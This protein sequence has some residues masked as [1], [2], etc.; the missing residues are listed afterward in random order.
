MSKSIS[1]ALR[2]HLAQECTTLA[3][4]WR[5]TRTDGQAFYLTDHD[6][7]LTIGGQTYLADS[8]YTRTAVTSSAGFRTDELEVTGLFADG[9]IEEIEVR[10]GLFD[11]AEAEIFLVDFTSPTTGRL[12]LRIGTLGEIKI[13][14]RRGFTAEIRGRLQALSQKIGGKYQPE[15]RADVGDSRCRVPIRPPLIARNTTYALGDF[16]HVETKSSAAPRHVMPLLNAG[17]EE[18]LAH[19]STWYG[20]P[21]VKDTTGAFAAHSGSRYLSGG[22]TW[23]F[24]VYQRFT[25]QTMASFDAAAIDGGHVTFHGSVYR[26]TTSDD[27]DR[28]RV[29]IRTYNEDNRRLS[30]LWDTP[31]GTIP[32]GDGWV[33][34]SISKT[35]TPG[36]RDLQIF[37]VATNDGTQA[38]TAAIDSIELSLE[39]PGGAA[40]TA[41]TE[42]IY[43]NRIY[44]VT[45]A[46]RTAGSQPTYDT[47]VGATTSDGTVALTARE[48]WTR[49]GTVTRGWSA[50][51]FAI[52]V[53]DARAVDGWWNGG[54]LVFETGA[55]KGY[56]GEVRKYVA[57][58]NAI[59]LFLP[60]P[61][62]PEAGDKIRIYPG[63]DR[64]LGTCKS[65]WA[66]PGSL[67]FARG[68]FLNFRG[69][70]YLPGRDRLA[71]YPDAK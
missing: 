5:I 35:L 54:A 12:T 69:E 11:A 43:E 70:P 55:N 67:R 15:C 13:T 2:R 52:D 30:F 64:R 14:P 7:D 26:A 23:G 4:C 49:H 25:I 21:E 16:V 6:R 10:N 36:T 53:T 47:A 66:I 1:G 57:T 71:K 3:T 46:G 33:Q 40:E 31:R 61:R 37:V 22:N 24:G 19:W 28:M 59:T 29:E 38:L 63:C 34:Q 62:T 9:V 32:R 50:Q 51:R 65:R 20:T 45:T 48:A 56:V 39:Y 58:G 27:L 17:F 42:E 60:A 18:G 68:N 8:G 41:V 44:E